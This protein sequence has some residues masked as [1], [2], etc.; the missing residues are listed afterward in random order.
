MAQIEVFTRA[1]YQEAAGA[2]RARTHHQPQVGLILGSGLNPLAEEVAGADR[3]AYRDIPYFPQPSVLGH[4]G[5]LVLGELAGQRVLIMQGR[6][7]GYEGIS[8]QRVTFPVRVMHELGVHTLIVT[9]A[10]GGINPSYQAG[11]LMLIVDHLALAAMAGDNPLR[12][13][14]DESLGPRFV[15]MT[16]TY[17]P[18]LRRLALQVAAGQG[19][20]LRQGVYAGLSGPTFETP[21]DVRFLRLAGADAVGMSTV[22]EVIVARHMGMRVLGL[23]GIT[24]QAID[25]PDSPATVAHEDVLAAGR[26]LVPRLMALLRGILAEMPAPETPSA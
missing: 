18:G 8:P 10:A 14:N 19:L 20:A 21:A 6:V 12:G 2:I 1:Q 11:D 3:V 25:D 16:R 22:G 26:A 5:T 9:N 15:D 13:P 24:N 7:H 4:A 17:D 23:S